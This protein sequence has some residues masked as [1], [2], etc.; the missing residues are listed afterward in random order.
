MI[1]TLSVP[2]D[3]TEYI[4]SSVEDED[5]VL[6]IVEDEKTKPELQ[7][8]LKK[9]EEEDQRLDELLDGLDNS[10]DPS[11]TEPEPSEDISETSPD[12]LEPS[13]NELEAMEKIPIRS[14]FS[15]SYDSATADVERNAGIKKTGFFQIPDDSTFEVITEEELQVVRKDQEEVLMKEV[16]DE[17][18]KEGE[19]LRKEVEKGEVEEETMEYGKF[20]KDVMRDM[21]EKKVERARDNEMRDLLDCVSTTATR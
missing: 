9:S 5:E 4:N 6:E 1:L 17:M 15:F 21:L 2:L 12:K 3:F 14:S 20:G 11:Q 19:E 8:V 13:M 7:L 18:R 10:N 16:E